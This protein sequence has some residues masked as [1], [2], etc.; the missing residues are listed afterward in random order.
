LTAGVVTYAAGWKNR[1]K[2]CGSCFRN[3]LLDT[4]C[5]FRWCKAIK[6]IS[7]SSNQKSSHIWFGV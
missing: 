7:K 3:T 4:V 1:H 5:H 2:K 6:K